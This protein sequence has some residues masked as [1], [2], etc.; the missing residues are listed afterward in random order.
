MAKGGFL[1]YKLLECFSNNPEG[2][3]SLIVW[4]ISAVIETAIISAVVAAIAFV[5]N[6]EN[7]FGE[8]FSGSCVVVGILEIILGFVGMIS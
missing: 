6:N 8:W 3:V 5:S 2:A 1:V 7:D 4:L